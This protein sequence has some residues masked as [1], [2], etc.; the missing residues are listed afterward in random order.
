M[1]P[2]RPLIQTLWRR[3]DVATE[4]RAPPGFEWPCPSRPPSEASQMFF[5]LKPFRWKW[6]NL[7]RRTLVLCVGWRFFGTALRLRCRSVRCNR[8]GVEL[9]LSAI[10][11]GLLGGSLG[12]FFFESIFGF[13]GGWKKYLLHWRC[14]EDF[15]FHG[16]SLSRVRCSPKK[17]SELWF[18]YGSKRIHKKPIGRGK[19]RAKPVGL[20][21]S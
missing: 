19:H 6:E 12:S 8:R 17:F 5:F 9:W 20:V 15:V 18:G 10:R 16:V 21:T 2:K 4:V 13:L 14:R 11:L 7:R 3:H 1:V